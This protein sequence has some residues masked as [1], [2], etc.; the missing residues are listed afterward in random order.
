M[1]A[2]KPLMAICL[3]FLIAVSLFT[4][5][6]RQKT[7]MQFAS[8]GASQINAR[9]N[10]VRTSL[11]STLFSSFQN[12]LLT[13]P[14]LSTIGQ[15][16]VEKTLTD[17][18]TRTA[19]YNFIG[20]NPGIQF[21]AICSGLGLSIGVVQFHLFQLRKTGLICSIRK[22]KYLRFFVTGKFSTKEMETFATLKLS[23]VRRIFKTLMEEKRASHHRLSAQL[24]ISSQGFTWQMHRLQETGFIQQEKNGLSITYSLNQT[25]VSVVSKSITIIEKLD[26]TNYCRGKKEN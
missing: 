15:P 19:I 8:A 1:K 24:K 2:A 3:A 22:G 5:I 18:T 10:F 21:R 4:L 25:Y 23:T 6:E 14:A 7:T 20:N 26:C 11:D 9:L 12:S 17:N 16:I 13:L